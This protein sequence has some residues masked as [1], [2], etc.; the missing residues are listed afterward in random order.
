MKYTTFLLSTLYFLS[1]YGCIEQELT[2]TQNDYEC[3]IKISNSH[4]DS[5]LFNS[6]L[7]E[8]IDEG[9]P[10]ITMLIKNN[11]G[12]WSGAAGLADI[13]NEVDMQSCNVNRV[14]SITKTFTAISILQLAEKDMLSLDDKISIYIDSNIISNIQNANT[15]TVKQLLNHTSGMP[16]FTDNIEY[17][18]DTYND[19]NKLWT[20]E[21][22]LE[23][24]YDLEPE[25]K[26]ESGTKLKYSNTNYVLL[27][28]IVE[29]VSGQNGAS[30]YEE[31][32]FK[33][34]SLDHTYF[35]QTD[36]NIPGLVK[37]YH[38]EFGDGLIRDFTNNPFAINSMAGG[39]ASNVRDLFIYI[40]S[41][42]TT[43][44]I[45]SQQSIDVML[46]SPSVP[47]ADVKE[48]DFGIDN[49]INSLLGI[50]LG[51]FILDTDYGIAIGHNGGFNGRRSRMWYFPESETSIIYMYNGTRFKELGRRMFRN[52]VL[53]LVFE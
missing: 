7:E 39:I 10:G 29:K 28:L 20:A 2:F 48:F 42:L 31:N 13:P 21:E 27:G 5:A 1:F 49:K 34:L 51:W 38:D 43:D 40:T 11:N 53:E 50:G 52:E 45:L 14:G 3:D 9:L 26:F 8:K 25:F 37:G 36:K 16:D 47:I 12:I 24:A 30:Y 6:Y 33:P 35:N 23:Y 15:S 46:E 18:L 41:V 44:L 19:Y 32:I 22:E 4:P 17:W